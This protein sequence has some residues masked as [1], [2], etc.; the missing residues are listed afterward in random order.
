MQLTVGAYLTTLFVYYL[1]DLKETASTPLS[2]L[3]APALI[4]LIIS[5]GH[6]KNIGSIIRM[7]TSLRSSY[8][9]REVL[10][11]GLFTLLL[12]LYPFRSLILTQQTIQVIHDYVSVAVGVLGIAAMV[13]IYVLPARPC[14]KHYYTPFS[15]VL[16]AVISGPLFVQLFIGVA[17]G[18]VIQGT[19][20]GLVIVALVVS[21]SLLDIVVYKKVYKLYLNMQGDETRACLL[22]LD[23]KRAGL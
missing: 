22:K 11:L 6:G 23:S 14:W 20:L 16:P 7:I 12:L 8:L 3:W 17:S 4:G 18:T 19:P 21:L 9:S 15:F 2:V 1:S 10:L 13:G 5:A